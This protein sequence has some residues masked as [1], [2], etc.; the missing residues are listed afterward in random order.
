MKN[1]HKIS[2]VTLC[3]VGFVTVSSPV[4]SET[5][6]SIITE[7]TIFKKVLDVRDGIKNKDGA[8]VIKDNLRVQGNLT[9]DEQI[10]V[11]LQADDIQVSAADS[12]LSATNLQDALDNQLAIDL[13][14][15]LNGSWTVVNTTN[16]I[17]FDGH[18]AEVRFVNGTL[19]VD[20]GRMAAGGLVDATNLGCSL[21]SSSISYQVF[22]S[23]MIYLEWES[24][25]YFESTVLTVF[26]QDENT[27]S[28]VGSGGMC[29]ENGIDRISTLTR[30][31]D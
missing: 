7:S 31:Q 12:N 29:G 26:A 23:N 25:G 9:V 3:L 19:I 27:L 22:G 6:R 17:A 21:P 14:T 16:D 4:W 28:V 1:Y 20:D 10:N 8:V 30:I 13:A 15:V 24:S 2:L 11:N 18:T 5:T